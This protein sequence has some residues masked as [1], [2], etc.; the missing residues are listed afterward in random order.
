MRSRSAGPI[1]LPDSPATMFEN[2]GRHRALSGVSQ[3]NLSYIGAFTAVP[4][5]GVTRH[6]HGVIRT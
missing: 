5:H 1:V 2:I 4:D 3:A 6:R